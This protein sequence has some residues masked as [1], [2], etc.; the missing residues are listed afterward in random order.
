[1]WAGPAV[2]AGL[3]YRSAVALAVVV[4]VK[5]AL[6]AK[7]S[8]MG[9]VYGFMA[10]LVANLMTSLLGFFVGGALSV[11]L[12]LPVGIPLVIA[13][14]YFGS[15]GL[16]DRLAHSRWKLLTRGTFVGGSLL[17]TMLSIG[18]ALFNYFP[19]PDRSQTLYW[20]AKIGSLFLG[21]LVSIPL[22]IAWEGVVVLRLTR[23]DY[24]ADRVFSAVVAANLWT[25][26]GAALIGA[27]IAVPQRMKDPEWMLRAE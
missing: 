7:F 5:C 2:G 9:A 1:M 22:T 10:M 24:D 25:L 14:A 23:D 13:A 19:D 8:P 17:L 18:L 15:A 11:P 3:L 16:G 26:L 21:L 4:T 20:A 12:M 6:F 27:A